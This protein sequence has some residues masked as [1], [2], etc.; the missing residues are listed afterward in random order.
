MISKSGKGRFVPDQSMLKPLIA[1]I[2]TEG[3]F[4]LVL[5]ETRQ[6]VVAGVAAFGAVF[7]TG[8]VLGAI[9]MLV[10]APHVGAFIATLIEAPL[11]LVASWIIT[12]WAIR[13]WGVDRQM[14]A[15]IKMGAIA[16]ALLI[17]AEALFGIVILGQSPGQWLSTLS[18]PAG[19][20][21]LTAQFTFG[22]M[23]V[24]WMKLPRSMAT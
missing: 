24:I 10:V 9:R 15:R 2:R 11:M 1:Q 6:V 17:V 21:G 8:F 7:S 4:I 3:R 22:F 12:G 5:I 13:R 14:S 18:T 16:F 20:T 19:S 23:P